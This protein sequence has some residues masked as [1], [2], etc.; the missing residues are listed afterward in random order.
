[1]NNK[2]KNDNLQ[3]IIY[4]VMAGFFFSLMTLF[5]RM[6]GDLPTLQKSFFRNSVAAVVSCVLLIRSSDGFKI[7]RKSWTSLLLRSIFGT[8]GL[9]CNFYAIDKIGLA[10]SNML[11]KLSPFFAIVMSVFILKEKANKIEWTAV[12]IAFVGALF[13]IKPSFNIS[14]V[15]GLAGLMGGF[16]AGVAYVFV[17]KL[18]KQGERGPVIVM[19]F[20]VFSSLTTL[21][22]FIMGFVP[23]TVIQWTLLLCAGIAATG[24]QLCIT[25]AYTKAPAKVISVFDYSQI[26]FATLW[27]IIF[28]NEL[29]D[30]YSFIGYALIIGVAVFKWWYTI[31]TDI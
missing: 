24:G 31:K 28:L 22:F 17:R 30:V 20:S 7:Q 27:G 14:S 21:P 16:G 26:M 19:F 11:N 2:F 6:S 29:P 18:G 9:T 5:V 15:Y 10:D 23:M 4:I 3:G 1:M 12:I 8:I 25:K 13:I